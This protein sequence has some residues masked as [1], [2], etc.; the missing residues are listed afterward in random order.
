MQDFMGKNPN[1][2]NRYK[3]SYFNLPK[4]ICLGSRIKFKFTSLLAKI[5]IILLEE[6]I[7]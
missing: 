7:F 3:L 1:N 2:L 6:T 5:L 4:V